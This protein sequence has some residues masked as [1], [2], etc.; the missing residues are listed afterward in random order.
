[1]RDVSAD[2]AYIKGES[3][4]F[5]QELASSADMAQVIG[6][7]SRAVAIVENIYDLLDRQTRRLPGR[8]L[9]A[10]EAE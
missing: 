9:P 6:D 3:A 10:N 4:S 8:W 1:M 2:Q 5:I 7:H